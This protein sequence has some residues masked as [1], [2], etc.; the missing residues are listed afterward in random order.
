[1]NTMHTLGVTLMTIGLCCG[2]A[3]GAASP[4]RYDVTWHSP[5]ADASGSMPLGNGDIGLNAWIEPSGE[6]V[7][8]ISKTDSWGDNARLLKVGRVRVR[9]APPLPVTEFRQTLRL[10]EGTMEAV[11]GE[12]DGATT[13]RLWV[14][15][16]HPVIHV[17]ADGKTPC[18]AT[19]SI[20][21]WRT[22]PYELPSIECSDVHLDRSKPDQKHAPTIVEP[23][24]VLDNLTDRIGW[25]H[26]NVKSVGPAQHAR[27]Q[28]MTGYKRPD[29]LLHRTFGAVISAAGGRRLDDTHLQSL[30]SNTH[31]LSVFVLTRHPSSPQQWLAA[32]EQTIADVEKQSFDDRRAAHERWWADFWNR[33]WVDVTTRDDA[34]AVSLIPKNRYSVKIGVDQSGGSRFGG[35]FGRVSIFATV[36]TDAEIAKLAQTPHEQALPS[37]PE[38]LIS[39]LLISATPQAGQAL[40]NSNDW[41]FNDGM[42]IEAWIKD[43]DG[44]RIVD[45][46]TPGG[47][48]GFLFDTHPRN[49]LRLIVGRETLLK[50]NAL[51]SG[52]WTHVAAVVNNRTAEIKTFINGEVAADSAT[53]IGDDA[54]VVSRAYALQRFIDACAGRGRYPIKFNGSIFTVPYPGKPGDGDYRRWGPGYWWQNTRLPYLSMCAAG[55]FE[56]MEPLMRMYVDDLLPL[57]RY[58][59]RHYFGHGGAYY[60]ECIQFWGDV[61]NETYGWTPFDERE[62]KLQTS[63]WHKWEWV[64]GLELV[65][66]MFDYYDYTLDEALLKNRLLPAAHEVLTFFDE[67]YSTDASGRLVMHPAQAVETWWDCTNPMPE[68]AGLH[69]LTARLLKLPE[70][71]TTTEQRAFWTALQKKLPPLPTR[72]VGEELAL[73]PAERFADKR[74]IENPELYAVFPFRLVSFEKENAALGVAALRHRWDRGNSG[75]RQDDVFMAYLGLADDARQHLVG[76][77]RNHHRGSRFPAF[78]GPNYDWIP[79]QDHGGVLMKALQAMV[80]QPDPYSQK[81]YLLPAWPKDWN[82]KFK[83]HAPYRTTVECEYRRGKIEEL[84]VTPAER[85]KDVVIAEARK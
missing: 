43:P 11:Y 82:V 26:H 85:R 41:A 84:K 7:F 25:Y 18:T 44:G 10:R 1:M 73:A 5:N 74:N 54:L 16:N 3:A 19:A 21:L 40:E 76:R 65:F 56:M 52:Q 27:T 37:R 53:V 2:R 17:T 55:D 24:T 81:I 63:G 20:E 6:L 70:S 15:A 78:W 12:G 4:D 8:Y 77:A 71:L 75:W 46:I 64:C 23:D 79:D 35:Q 72:K 62:D 47:A 59:T 34:A 9:L 57:A 13:I 61:F 58:R 30:R 68:L 14:D 36:L 69:A 39:T 32:M 50:E 49:S 66:M 51:P 67:H 83:L 45:C 22:G 38:L 33:S 31:R 80:L 60:P 28:G 48:D 29:P 42:T